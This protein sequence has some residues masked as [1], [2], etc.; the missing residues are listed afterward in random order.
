VHW[1]CFTTLTEQKNNR[2]LGPTAGLKT[3][4]YKEQIE[5]SRWG[6]V[7]ESRNAHRVFAAFRDRDPVC[8]GSR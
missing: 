4:R 1:G 7:L 5:D 6:L 3:G 8:P 2:E